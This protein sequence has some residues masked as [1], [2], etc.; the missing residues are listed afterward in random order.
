MSNHPRRRACQRA[1]TPDEIRTA[2]LAA[3]WTQQTAAGALHVGV[4]MYRQYENGESWMHTAFFELLEHKIRTHLLVP[5]LPECD[6]APE[7]DSSY[8]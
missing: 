2:Q 5:G 4:A 3:G 1:P 7:F 8:T 6:R